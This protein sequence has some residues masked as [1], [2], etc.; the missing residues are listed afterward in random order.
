MPKILAIDYGDKRVGLA[1]AEKGLPIALPLDIIE[2]K[3]VKKLISEISEICKKEEV[4][5]IV[6]GYPMGLS[7][8]PTEQTQK[9][10]KFI[11]TMKGKINLPIDT[12]NEV[13]TSR[14]ARGIFKDAGIKKQH[15]DESSAILI[16]ADYLNRKPS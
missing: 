13:F 7:G 16:L 4:Y 6:V 10:E 1:V 9:V 11:E 5:Q 14:E 8:K 12:Q 3:G 2:N 15:I